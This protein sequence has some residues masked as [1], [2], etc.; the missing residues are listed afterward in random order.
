M[1]PR[2]GTRTVCNSLFLLSH[3][4]LILIVQN[5]Y[6]SNYPAPPQPAREQFLIP[7]IPSIPE[8]NPG[9]ST[10]KPIFQWETLLPLEF[11]TPQSFAV[12]IPSVSHQ[13]SMENSMEFL[14][15]TD[16]LLGLGLFFGIPILVRF[17]VSSQ[18][19]GWV[20][21][22]KE[23][24]RG[25]PRHYGVDAHTP[26]HGSAQ[27]GTDGTPGN[28]SVPSVPTSAPA[29]PRKSNLG[30][31]RAPR[32]L[33]KLLGKG[34]AG[35]Q[36]QMDGPGSQGRAKSACQAAVI[37]GAQMEPGSGCPGS[38]KDSGW[39]SLGGAHRVPG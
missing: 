16:W 8:A 27:N 22:V 1:L 4:I 26:C 5:F 9:N 3:I 25:N 19:A 21:A 36:L 17:L 37:L 23:F 24:S 7:Y 35:M 14:L 39:S 15:L 30:P 32:D 2:K 31:E 18:Q 10:N 38:F 11:S 20:W 12:D 6:Y 13:A 33:C 29:L 28:K 34:E